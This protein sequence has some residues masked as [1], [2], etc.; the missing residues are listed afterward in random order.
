MHRKIYILLFLFLGLLTLTRSFFLMRQSP[1]LD[2]AIYVNLAQ[3]ISDKLTLNN[4]LFPIE[5]GLSPLFIY[6]TAIVIKFFSN[7]FF[8]GRLI[9]LLISFSTTFVL[10]FYLKKIKAKNIILPVLF[11]YF[12]PFTWMYSQMAVLETTMLFI[13]ALFLLQTE[14]VLKK[15]N[16]KNIFLLAIIFMLVILS[17][18][19]GCFIALYFFVKSLSQKK[20]RAIILFIIFAA[21]IFLSGLPILLKLFTIFP[22]HSEKT[23]LFQIV[24]IKNN[25]RLMLIWIKDYFQFA[26]IIILGIAAII[27]RKKMETQIAFFII[28]FMLLFF[29]LVATNI[30]PRYLYLIILMFCLILSFSGNKF[31]YAALFL[32]MSAYYL[33]TNYKIMFDLKN[34]SIAKEDVYQY[35][36]DW[37]SGKNILKIFNQAEKGQTICIV[38]NEFEYFNIIKKSFY[39]NKE[40]LLKKDCENQKNNTARTFME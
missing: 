18:Y 38:G 10:F 7:P 12:N 35:D 3:G 17:K 11:L 19:T 29:S 37:T 9:S 33:P 27:S 22:M 5:V 31:L 1:F 36:T 15:P 30:F 34:A 39:Q 6:F 21:I 16:Y 2:E 40:L 23:Q 24:L 32:L 20:Y 8:S 13:A 28:L 14:N 4:I 25:F 26:A